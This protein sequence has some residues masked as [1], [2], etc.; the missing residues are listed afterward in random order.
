MTSA[1]ALNLLSSLLAFLIGAATREVYQRRKALGPARRVWRWR[2]SETVVVQSDGPG[3][4]TPLPTLYQG[5]AAA[6]DA[7]ARYLRDGLHVPS[8]RTIRASEFSRC[9]DEQCDLVVV[10]GP[11]A[12]ELYLALDE[13]VEFPYEFALYPDRADLIRRS[14]GMLLRQEVEQGRTVRDFA[15]ISLMASPY[16]PGRGL[17]V[18]AGCGTWG[19]LAAS[20]LVTDPGIARLAALRPSAPAFTV[21]IEIEIIDGLATHARFVDQLAWTPRTP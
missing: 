14:D 21:V 7:V 16:A 12:N 9:R 13:L 18:L 1:L 15:C 19:T 10:G 8:V 2:G 6:S 4:G 20:R 3:S 11:N 17:V 5:D